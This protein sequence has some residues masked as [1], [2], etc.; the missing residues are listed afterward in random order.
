MRRFI[1]RL[2]IV[3]IT[4]SLGIIITPKSRVIHPHSPIQASAGRE[5]Y[6]PGQHQIEIK[7]RPISGDGIYD[8]AMLGNNQV[9]AVG[10]DSHDSRIMWHSKD[11]GRTWETRIAPT[12]EWT[13]SSIHFVNH[14]HGW[15]TGSGNALI[16]TSDGGESWQRLRLP[17][18]MSWIR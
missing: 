17:V 4:F 10:Q 9:W 12:E 1:F 5:S 11:G 13:L 15:A 6:G 14:Q 16:R 2:P 7:L 18:Y 3:F 8:V